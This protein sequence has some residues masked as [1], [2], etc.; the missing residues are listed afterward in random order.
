VKSTTI[1]RKRE[2]LEICLRENVEMERS[3]GFEH[4]RFLHEALPEIAPEDVEIRTSF[5]GRELT[6]P[7][8]ISSMTGGV[9]RGLQINRHLAGAAEALGIA[10]AVGSQRVALRHPEA[11]KSFAVVREVAPDVPV[12]ANLGATQLN[13][14]YGI[15][16]LRRAVGMIGADGLFLHLNPLQEAIQERGNTDYRNLAERIGE[17]TAGLGRPVLVKEV[18]AGISPRTARL[19]A[20]RGVAAIDVSGA[21]GTSWSKIEALR[22]EDAER[23]ELGLAFADW[24]IPTAQSLALCRAELPQLP[25]IASGGIRDGITAAKALALGADLVGLALPLLGAADQSQEAVER[26]LRRFARELR[27]VMFLVGARSLEELRRGHHLV[28]ELP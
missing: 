19:L 15:P 8:L 4:Y 28:A 3:T 26:M 2:H 1:E 18:G 14:G 6:M 11:A 10:M 13:R 12:Y 25:L 27:L 7:F 5:L 20:D 23:R 9:E 22:A 21:G 24:G 17:V 16:E